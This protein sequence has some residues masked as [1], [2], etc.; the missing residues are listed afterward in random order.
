MAVAVCA[1]L[2]AVFLTVEA[3]ARDAADLERWFL[4]RAL[5]SAAG[6]GALAVSGVFVL[7]AD[8][9]RLFDRLLGPGLP[10][11][12]V[13]GAAGLAS[14]LL[15]TGVR[16][17][18]SERAL[19]VLAVVAVGSLVAGWGVA[20]YPYLLGTHLTITAA[21]APDATLWSVVV[22]F[23]VAGAVV[24]PSLGLLYILQQKGSLEGS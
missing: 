18:A 5:M 16:G 8:A 19:R 23:L 3:R 17:Q 11:V 13:S 1:Y 22:V 21:A 20:Q 9:P 24:L 12:A 15:A 14:L 10:L 6:A 4:R 7:H 2:A